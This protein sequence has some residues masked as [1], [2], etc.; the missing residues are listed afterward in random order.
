[1]SRS[2]RPTG[3]HPFAGQSLIRQLRPEV[4]A[5]SLLEDSSARAEVEMFAVVLVGE[6]LDTAIEGNPFG[7]LPKRTQVIGR[8]ACGWKFAQ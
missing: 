6:V 1:M 4:E 2:A 5:D 7:W 8:E 3:S